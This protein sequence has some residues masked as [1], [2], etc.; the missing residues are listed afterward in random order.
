MPSVWVPVLTAT[1]KLDGKLD[2]AFWE[3][4]ARL[5]RFK[6][7]QGHYAPA[8][9]VTETWIATTKDAL[10]MA[11]RCHEN[12]I[13]GL[14]APKKKRDSSIWDDDVIE[15]FLQI[16]DDLDMP[17]Y[18]IDINAGGTITDEYA[19][20][21][22]WDAEGMKAVPGREDKAWT[23]EV[24]I[25]FSDL[26]LLDRPEQNRR[27]RMNVIRVRTKH[28]G[29]KAGRGALKLD[30]AGQPYSEETAWSPTEQRSSLVPHRFG[31]AYLEVFGARPPAEGEGKKGTR[32]D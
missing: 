1:P 13:A 15:I 24:M 7:M 14:K 32:G 10:Y 27:W 2:D 31:F 20:R 4:A 19:R 11:F 6:T 3:K 23:M 21:K 28:K 12:D 5:P 30:A 9:P 18:Q 8:N 26:V 29:D 16:S 17:W 22:V 25:P